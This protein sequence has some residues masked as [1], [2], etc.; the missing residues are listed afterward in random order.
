M[1]LDNE[2]QKK[3]LVTALNATNWPGQVIE[4]VVKVKAA[5]FH[6]RIL[7]P[8]DQAAGMPLDKK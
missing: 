4:E 3:I 6:A 7:E 1:T 2:N 8:T 5:V